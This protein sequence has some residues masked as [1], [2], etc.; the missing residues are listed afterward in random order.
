MDLW[1]DLLKIVRDIKREAIVYLRGYDLD[2]DVETERIEVTNFMNNPITLFA[3]DNEVL[4]QAEAEIII[5]GF[6]TIIDQNHLTR[7]APIL[8]MIF[9]NAKGIVTCEIRIELNYECWICLECPSRAVQFAR[10]KGIQSRRKFWLS[11]KGGP[12]LADEI[13]FEAVVRND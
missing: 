2:S 12:E 13:N 1:E 8:D 11:F 10:Q 5:D 9:Q 7:Y 3:S 6:A 4:L